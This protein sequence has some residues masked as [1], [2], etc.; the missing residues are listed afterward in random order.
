MTHNRTEYS[1]EHHEVSALIPWYVNETLDEPARKRV[2]AH[3]DAC[4]ICRDDLAVQRRICDGIHAQPALDYMPVAS[5]KRLH[6]RLDAMQ[7]GSAP[8]QAPALEQ[9]SRSATPWRGWMA[10]SVAAVAVAVGLVVVDRWAQFD[11]RLTQPKYSTV[12]TAVPRPQ[13]EVIRAVFAPNITL[14]ELQSILDEAQ[15]RIVSG[16]TEAGVYSLASNSALT[17]RAS[18]ALLRQHPTVRFA[19]GTLPEPESGKSP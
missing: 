18:L 5:L 6:M 1:A 11:S 14:I 8:V 19:E 9:Q 17:M 16:P 12:T 13:G 10:A 3:V 15:L 4:A 2:D 7:A